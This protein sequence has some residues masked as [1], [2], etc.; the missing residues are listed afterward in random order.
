MA[1]PEQPD[2]CV[3][4]LA[5]LHT[6]NIATPPVVTFALS[7]LAKEFHPSEEWP[8]LPVTRSFVACPKTRMQ[9][10]ARSLRV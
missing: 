2:V 7:P 1:I 8:A 5:G 10:R 3:P 6:L 9:G 4:L